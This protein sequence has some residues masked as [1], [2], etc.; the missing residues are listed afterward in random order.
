M[1]LTLDFQDNVAVLTHDD[2]KRNA[3]SPDCIRDFNSALDEV[4]AKSAAH[5]RQVG[6]WLVPANLAHLRREWTSCSDSFTS[7]DNGWAGAHLRWRPGA[8]IVHR[9]RS[10]RSADG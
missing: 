5:Y 4:E 9:I 7:S 2:G 8:R 10:G 3:F 6:R 1:S